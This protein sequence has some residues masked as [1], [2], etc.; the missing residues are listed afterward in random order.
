MADDVV[1]KNATDTAW[2]VYRA[3]HPDV[4]AHDGRR[5][6]M[7]RHLHRRWEERQSDTEEL[8][9]FGLAYLY[10]LPRDEC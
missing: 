2:T 4:D 3:R 10:R 5:C 7:E 1:L 8:A 6:L 9:T